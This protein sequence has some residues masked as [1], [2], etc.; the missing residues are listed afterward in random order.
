MLILLSEAY[1]KLGRQKEAMHSARLAVTC[2]QRR[3]ALISIDAART[4][5]SFN[6]ICPLLDDSTTLLT[7]YYNLATLLEFN[8]SSE[9]LALQWYLRVISAADEV[10]PLIIDNKIK[11]SST[12]RTRSITLEKSAI[13]N[14][15]L[16]DLKFFAAEA[17]LRLQLK[18]NPLKISVAQQS[19]PHDETLQLCDAKNNSTQNVG[20]A[21]SLENFFNAD[22]R[23]LRDS[24]TQEE[25]VDIHHVDSLCPAERKCY[26]HY[27]YRTQYQQPELFQEIRSGAGKVCK[28][29]DVDS[30]EKKLCLDDEYYGEVQNHYARQLGLSMSTSPID[31]NSKKSLNFPSVDFWTRP[32]SACTSFTFDSVNSSKSRT[33]PLLVAQ[34][35]EFLSDIICQDLH[36]PDID[37]YSLKK[38]DSPQLRTVEGSRENLPIR[39]HKT[40]DLCALFARTSKFSRMKNLVNGADFCMR[41]V[42]KA[43]KRRSSLKLDASASAASLSRIHSDLSYIATASSLRW[44]QDFNKTIDMFV[45]TP[46]LRRKQMK[47]EKKKAAEAI[48]RV[49][50]D[51]QR[52]S[53]ERAAAAKKLQ[54]LYRGY[55]AR[56][57]V[58][59]I[60]RQRLFESNRR[61]RRA[62]ALIIQRVYRGHYSRICFRRYLYDL[63][64]VH[65]SPQR[66]SSQACSTTNSDVFTSLSEN[67]TIRLN[68]WNEE[69][70]G[71]NILTASKL[72]VTDREDI[73]RSAL[74]SSNCVLKKGRTLVA[75]ARRILDVDEE[76]NAA[77]QK[78]HQLGSF[79]TLESYIKIRIDSAKDVISESLVDNK[80]DSSENMI[81]ERRTHQG[82]LSNFVI[83]EEVPVDAEVDIFFRGTIRRAMIDH[84]SNA[85]RGHPHSA[86]GLEDKFVA[87]NITVTNCSLQKLCIRSDSASVEKSVTVLGIQLGIGSPSSS[88][89]TSS[90]SDVSSVRPMLMIGPIKISA[91]DPRIYRREFTGVERRKDYVLY[92]APD[93]MEMED[94]TVT[95]VSSPANGFQDEG[96]LSARR[97]S[98]NS[99]LLLEKVHTSGCSD[100]N[101]GVNL[102]EQI[103]S[104]ED[105]QSRGF[106]VPMLVRIPAKKGRSKSSTVKKKPSL[107]SVIPHI[108]YPQTHFSSAP[109]SNSVSPRKSPNTELNCWKLGVSTV[110][111]V[112]AASTR[113][114]NDEDMQSCVA[115]VMSSFLGK[116]AAMDRDTKSRHAVKLQSLARGYL[117]RCRHRGLLNL[118]RRS[119]ILRKRENEI[120]NREKIFGDLFESLLST[121]KQNAGDSRKYPENH[122]D[123]VGLQQP[124]LN[125]RKNHRDEE[126]LVEVLS[127]LSLQDEVQE[128]SREM[129]P[130]TDTDRG[131]GTGTGSDMKHQLKQHEDEEP[132]VEVLSMLSLQDE[133]QEISREMTPDTDTDTDRGTGTGTGSDMKHQLKQHEDEEPLVEVLSMLSL[134]DEVQEISREMTPDTDTDRG[135]GT[136]AGTGTGS[137]MKHQLKQHEDEEPLVEVLS[138]LSS[139]EKSEGLG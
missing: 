94:S 24:F 80:N 102:M 9:H 106:V 6:C 121:S 72:L 110:T 70:C 10:F 132:L 81:H 96:Q 57:L 130:D 64:C 28:D 84:L 49:N 29:S 67:C 47:D 97:L 73:L 44:T 74:D 46:P 68:E 101:T 78:L 51:K 85:Q 14:K 45:P 99:D 2:A 129:T 3:M 76:A 41:E 50:A 36:H 118:L 88:V 53:K 126:P 22:D 43:G 5:Q 117:E 19:S 63:K 92:K 109:V 123:T 13:M 128:I 82:H 7:S 1:N 48:I 90:V 127:M 21:E 65:V 93:M 105:V 35:N 104:P 98:E 54:R 55:I 75:E 113:Q 114:S 59:A 15:Q 25:S 30:S 138:M 26:E 56:L 108:H 134:Q 115:R 62:A 111:K 95:N 124:K 32:H 4:Q 79:N 100:V 91:D 119:S 133:V 11:S 103:V 38:I 23:T 131:T 71:H 83:P 27:R 77:E 31:Q 135:T 86:V 112:S 33:M 58:R 40:E 107:T 137:D 20:E 69:S 34:N 122:D 8:S 61:N 120:T 17:A 60:R 136:G 37:L 42:D 87:P 66:Q 39:S 89:P 125:S 18:L 116:Q 16:A 139:R 52:K 12:T